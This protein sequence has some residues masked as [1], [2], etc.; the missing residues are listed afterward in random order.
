MVVTGN[1]LT[2]KGPRTHQGLLSM[3][4]RSAEGHVQLT[5]MAT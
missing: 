4:T 5:V 3:A 2:H 1:G